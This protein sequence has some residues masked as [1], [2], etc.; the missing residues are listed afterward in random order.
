MTHTLVIGV[1]LLLVGLI[2]LY[3]GYN[4]KKKSKVLACPANELKMRD[5][6]YLMVS[7]VAMLSGVALL[8]MRHHN[9][10]SSLYD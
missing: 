6:Q 4:D 5:N 9:S 2:G 10:I 7:G 8:A 1:V 3:R